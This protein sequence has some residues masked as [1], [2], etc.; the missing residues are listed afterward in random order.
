[1]INGRALVGDLKATLAH[2]EVHGIHVDLAGVWFLL[3]G[4]SSVG[5]LVLEDGHLDVDLLTPALSDGLY[6]PRKPRMWVNG[7]VNHELGLRETVH[8]CEVLIGI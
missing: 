1:M 6:E 5:F 4:T 7:R 8:S 2:A 3:R